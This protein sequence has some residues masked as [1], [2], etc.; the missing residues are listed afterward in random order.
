M[1]KCSEN[2]GESLLNCFWEVGVGFTEK[3]ILEVCFGQR[4]E[5]WEMKEGP[6][7]I[8][9]WHNLNLTVLDV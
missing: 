3:P 9:V 8:E 2:T 1:C 6:F 5:V 7:G 4:T